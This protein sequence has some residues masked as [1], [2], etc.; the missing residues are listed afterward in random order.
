MTEIIENPKR[1]NTVEV[2]RDIEIIKLE[3][4]TI[5]LQELIS[6][7]ET[8]ISA[9]TILPDLYHDALGE[10]TVLLNKFNDAIRDLKQ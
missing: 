3:S 2:S 9:D 6:E 8:N 4:V 7:L 5:K 1:E 10:T